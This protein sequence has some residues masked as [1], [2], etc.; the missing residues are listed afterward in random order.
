MEFRRRECYYPDDDALPR[1]C[2]EN[3][4]SERI[5][6]TV[7]QR[8]QIERSVKQI[9]EFVE[10]RH[11]RPRVTLWRQFVTSAPITIRCAT[12]PPFAF[13]TH[14]ATEFI[15]FLNAI[16]AGLPAGNAGHVILGN[17]AATGIPMCDNGSI[18]MSASHSTSRQNR[19]RGSTPSK[20]SSQNQAAM[21]SRVPRLG[22]RSAGRYQSLRR[23]AQHWAEAHHLD[24]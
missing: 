6:C 1:G 13:K 12:V 19:F 2:P 21:E 10:S 11:P 22:R 17:Y 14:P 8:D 5:N 18:D 23:R 9:L 3:R 24:R 16:E 4:K 20:P 15:R 7:H